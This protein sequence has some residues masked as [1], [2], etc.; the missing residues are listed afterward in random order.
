MMKPT[1]KTF[2]N[3]ACKT[4]PVKIPRGVI[5]K[6]SE[7][8]DGIR[9]SCQLSKKILEM[10]AKKIKP[11]ITTNDIND[12]VH[13]YTINQGATPAPLNYN[14]FPKSVCTSLNNV[15]CHGIPDNTVIKDGD[16]LN[17]DIT[18][19]HNGY[20]GDVG[21]M[22]NIGDV[23]EEAKK[24]VRVAEECLYLGIEKVKPYNDIGEIGYAIEQYANSHGYSVVRDYGG[25]GIGLKFH[26]EPHV[27]H[28]GNKK[29]GIIMIPDMIF[30]IEPMI[31]TGSYESVLLSDGW[32]ATTIDGGLSAQCE[33]TVRVTEA[34]VEILTE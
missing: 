5:I 3:E 17:V 19:I 6:T 8:I 10:V 14:G 32:T 29:R 21:R 15:I 27:H 16:I 34:G 25:H 20:F 18:T 9:K 23:S 12:W 22:F 4:R 31:N 1:K 30:T 7:Q 11:G 2:E 33:H 24:L 26:E 13:K 28:Y